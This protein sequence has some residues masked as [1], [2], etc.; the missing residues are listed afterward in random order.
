MRS[1]RIERPSRSKS[2]SRSDSADG[3]ASFVIAKDRVRDIGWLFLAAFAARITVLAVARATGRFPEFWEYETIARNILAGEGFVYRLMG[4]PHV[5]YVEPVYPF[6][7]TAVYFVAGFRLMVLGVLQSAVAAALAPVVY[8]FALRTFGRR[9]AIA[10]GALIALH[11]GLAGYASK[12]HPLSFDA[13]AIALVAL[14]LLR[15]LAAPNARGAA[16]FGVATGVCVLTRPTVLVFV[17]ATLVWLAVRRDRRILLHA[18]AGIV[19]ASAVV[20]PWAVRNYAH[21]GTFVLTRSHV[22][23]NFWLGNHPGATGGEGDPTD[24]TGARSLFDRAPAEFRS[25]VLSQPDE[26]AQDRLFWSAALDYVAREPLAF[27]QRT[28]RKFVEFWWFPAYVGRRYGT[29]EMLVYRV[30]YG[31]A[32]ALAVLGLLHAQR[33]PHAVEGHGVRVV[34]LGLVTIAAAQSLFYVQGRHRLAVE[35][36]LMILSGHGLVTLVTACHRRER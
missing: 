30:F 24:P 22:G 6:F 27:M 31:G 14:T 19:I 2:R 13:L 5:A 32:L 21:L 25:R 15:L 17:A 20:A 12:L 1:P 33:R 7:V 29:T 3:R 18:V 16:L 26:I 8:A 34:L 10:A 35:P 4:I 36:L 11:P 9:S 23:F 28:A